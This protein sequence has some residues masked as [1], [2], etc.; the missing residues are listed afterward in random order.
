MRIRLKRLRVHSR[1]HNAFGVS[2]YRTLHIMLSVLFILHML[3]LVASEYGQKFDNIL[4]RLL[5][6]FTFI[7]RKSYQNYYI[8]FSSIKVLDQFRTMLTYFR[9]FVS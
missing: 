2:R 6:Y 9:S 5:Y 4:K 3:C 7:F 1:Y 8:F